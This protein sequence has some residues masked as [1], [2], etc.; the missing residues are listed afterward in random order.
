MARL[1]RGRLIKRFDLPAV[2]RKLVMD[3]DP[4]NHFDNIVE[5]YE[6]IQFHVT[7]CTIQ[8]VKDWVY[9]N[10]LQGI[11]VDQIYT[12]VTE[13]PLTT[14]V[15]GSDAVGCSIYI[16][17]KFFTFDAPAGFPLFEEQGGWYRVIKP[18]NSFNGVQSSCQAYLVKDTVPLDDK[19][20]TKY[21]D[22][23]TVEPHMKTRKELLTNTW[24][25]FFLPS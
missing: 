2:Y 5:S 14:P 11:S 9:D 3:T 20:R 10:V 15:D 6:Q 22:M 23:T 19:G 24:K 1:R 8:P 16:P 18:K 21:P 13:S 12:I 17:S 7:G 4:D 25:Q